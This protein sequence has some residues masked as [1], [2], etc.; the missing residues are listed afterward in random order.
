LLN[1]MFEIPS[2]PEIK[3]C[4]ISERSIREALEPEFELGEEGESPARLVGESA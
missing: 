4:L 1:S 3:R 2:R